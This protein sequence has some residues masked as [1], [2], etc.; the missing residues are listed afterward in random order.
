MMNPKMQFHCLFFFLL[1]KKRFY[2][3]SLPAVAYTRDYQ[4]QLLYL[5]RVCGILAGPNKAY[6]SW[7][8]SSCSDTLLC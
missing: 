6:L 7:L 4:E 5:L 3:G 2:K 1:L 8:A